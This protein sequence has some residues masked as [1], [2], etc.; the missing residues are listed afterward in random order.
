MKDTESC[1]AADGTT[2]IKLTPHVEEKEFKEPEFKD[3]LK[4]PLALDDGKW[5]VF[6]W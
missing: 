2:E 1:L 5:A 4:K 3:P 6:C